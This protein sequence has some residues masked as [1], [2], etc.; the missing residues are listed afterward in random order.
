MALVEY[1]A[2]DK[3]VEFCAS[4]YDEISLVINHRKIRVTYVYFHALINS[5]DELECYLDVHLSLKETLDVILNRMLGKLDVCVVNNRE[6]GK[7]SWSLGLQGI[8]MKSNCYFDSSRIFSTRITLDPFAILLN[9]ENGD[10]IVLIN[11]EYLR[12]GSSK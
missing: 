5:D 8:S 2:E 1:N 9:K 7:G 6:S 4:K 11:E 3:V 12:G 10:D